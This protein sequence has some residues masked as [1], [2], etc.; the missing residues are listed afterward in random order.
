MWYR[1]FGLVQEGFIC[2]EWM[3]QYVAFD[4][5]KAFFVNGGSC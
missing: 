5:E 4:E 3:F 1:I 2:L